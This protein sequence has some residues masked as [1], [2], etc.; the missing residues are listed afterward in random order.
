[1]CLRLSGTQRILTFSVTT[2]EDNLK[3]T[4][5]LPIAMEGKFGRDLKKKLKERSKIFVVVFNGK[6][7]TL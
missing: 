5:P 7:T 4:G 3:S 2:M 1:M 6:S